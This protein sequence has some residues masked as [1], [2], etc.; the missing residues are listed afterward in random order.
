MK[1]IIK[2]VRE[3]TLSRE[4]KATPLYIIMIAFSVFMAARVDF[5]RIL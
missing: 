4:L 5:N 3:T 2:Y 1:T